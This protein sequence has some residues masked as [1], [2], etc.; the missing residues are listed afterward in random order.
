MQLYNAHPVLRFFTEHTQTHTPHTHTPHTHT[1]AHPHTHT[2]TST[3]TVQPECFCWPSSPRQILNSKTSS[4]KVGSCL[5]MSC[6]NSKHSSKVHRSILTCPI[7]VLYMSYICPIYVLYMSYICPIYVPICPLYVPYM[8]HI[9][10]LYV[11]IYVPYMSLICP[12]Y[13]PYMSTIC[14]IYVLLSI[15]D[16]YRT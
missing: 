6:R 11:P 9:C 15:G 7:Y 4:A 2:G 13:V 5:S 10:P 3:G 16:I 1:L 14:P 8:S 12:L